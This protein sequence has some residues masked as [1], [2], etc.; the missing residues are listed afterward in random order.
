RISAQAKCW[1][2]TICG[3][4]LLIPATFS[5]SISEYSAIHAQQAVNASI[6][7]AAPAD[8]AVGTVSAAPAAMEPAAF[9][10]APVERLYEHITVLEILAVVWAAVALG[11]LLVHLLLYLLQ[12]RF[13]RK[14]GEA[15]LDGDMRSQLEQVKAEMR[16]TRPIQLLVC[17]KA[18]SPMLLGLFHSCLVLPRLDFTL[19]QLAIIMRHELA[20]CKRRDLLVKWL[21]LLVRSVH[22]FNPLAHIL[23]KKADFD[24]ESACDDTV[25]RGKDKSYRRQYGNVL[26]HVLAG[27]RK[28]PALSTR[29]SGNTKEIIRRFQNIIRVEPR[30]RGIVLLCCVLAGM[31]ALTS[32]LN[33]ATARTLSANLLSQAQAAETTPQKLAELKQMLTLCV[34]GSVFDAYRPF[35]DLPLNTETYKRCE[36]AE[37]TYRDLLLQY[38]ESWQTREYVENAFFLAVDSDTQE[39]ITTGIF[40]CQNDNNIQN[41]ALSLIWLDFSAEND[42]QVVDIGCV[43]PGGNRMDEKWNGILEIEKEQK[44]IA[45]AFQIDLS[46]YERAD[47]DVYPIVVRNQAFSIK[48]SIQKQ[49]VKTGRYQFEKFHVNH[50]RVYLRKDDTGGVL[51]NLDDN[52]IYA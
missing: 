24:L 3:V 38:R 40:C 9:F 43:Y 35:R 49:L 14:N 17:E 11:F 23:A 33:P 29:F 21:F 45:D 2:W 28:G 48:S 15:V 50:A 32:G 18:D 16:V 44:Q 7:A 46:Q 13:L 34:K 1:I 30:R 26:L 12:A 5:F 41:G 4:R 8:S 10:Q 6:S 25:L 52:G 27:Q 51:L 37:T 19:E 39:P 36:Q 47:S 42:L 31:L 20:H 22:W